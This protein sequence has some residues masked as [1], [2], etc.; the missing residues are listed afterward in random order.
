MADLIAELEK[1]F[2]CKPDD[3]KDPYKLQEGKKSS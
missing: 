3:W 1:V 2:L